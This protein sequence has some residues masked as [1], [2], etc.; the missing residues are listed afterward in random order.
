MSPLADRVA[1]LVRHL[2]HLKTVRT[3]VKSADDL[4]R[5]LSLSNDVLFSLLQVSQVV[6]DVGSALSIE[7]GLPFGDYTEA[8][9]NL[10]AL[11]WLDPAVVTALEPLPAFRNIV[12]HE[13]AALDY[14]RVLAALADLEPVERFAAA[15]ARHLTE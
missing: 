10:R 2:D 4:R 6:V 15:V 8:V 14:D 12:V 11:P 3:K 1:E 7:A 5:D 13:Y 9:R